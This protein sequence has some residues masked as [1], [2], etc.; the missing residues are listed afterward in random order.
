MHF[1][2]DMAILKN[3]GALRFEPATFH[4]NVQRGVASK[5]FIPIEI[6][7]FRTSEMFSFG[8]QVS[9]NLLDYLLSKVLLL[10]RPEIFAQPV[11]VFSGRDQLKLS[12]CLT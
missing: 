8:S 6:E 12:H 9:S 4:P 3:D 10:P 1:N 5:L 2:R 11:V 7:T